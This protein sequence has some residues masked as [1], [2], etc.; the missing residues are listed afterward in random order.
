MI[1]EKGMFEK[2]PEETIVVFLKER[3]R[4]VFRANNATTYIPFI[5]T[6]Y[7]NTYNKNT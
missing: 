5:I 3:I 2:S 6:N 4:F 7:K 1:D